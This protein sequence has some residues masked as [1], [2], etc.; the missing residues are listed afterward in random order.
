MGEGSATD[1]SMHAIGSSRSFKLP[2]VQ[3]THPHAHQ[4]DEDEVNDDGDD[5]P[6]VEATG[7]P[8]VFTLGPRHR[9]WPRLSA[10]WSVLWSLLLPLVFG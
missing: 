10:T 4:Q 3:T 8:D 7:G 9:Y 5:V 1:L 2:V 6:P